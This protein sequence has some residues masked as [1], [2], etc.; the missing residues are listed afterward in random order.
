MKFSISKSSKKNLYQ[1]GS[2]SLFMIVSILVFVSFYKKTDKIRYSETIELKLNF[3]PNPVELIQYCHGDNINLKNI[4]NI[5]VY[6]CFYK[7]IYVDFI[8]KI[9]K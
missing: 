9:N 1:R 3:E 5:Y 6:L 4:K 8:Y 2:T 7:F